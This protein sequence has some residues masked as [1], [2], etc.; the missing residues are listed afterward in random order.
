[1]VPGGRRG[2]LA[3]LQ[4]R[5]TGSTFIAKVYVP[6]GTEADAA[7]L[8]RAKE[9]YHM[10]VPA[11]PNEGLKKVGSLVILDGDIVAIGHFDAT[12]EIACTRHRI[13][14]D[15]TCTPYDG[16][17]TELVRETVSLEKKYYKAEVLEYRGDPTDLH[18]W[19]QRVITQ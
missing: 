2:P 6:A 3:R 5:F 11:R 15:G 7:A 13:S 1:M 19:N 8:I 10:K 14:A 17:E 18:P 12:G 16:E 9:L 4:T